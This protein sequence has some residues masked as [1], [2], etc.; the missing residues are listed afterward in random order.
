MTLG[1]VLGVLFLEGNIFQ[2]LG[3][4]I[5][6]KSSKILSCVSL[7]GEPGSYPRLRYYLLTAPPWSLHPLPS[8]MSDS[9]NLPF[10]PQGRS[11]SLKLIP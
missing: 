8:L 10:G 2:L 7:E 6:Q 4:L 11:W 9:L 1:L 3:G 5:L